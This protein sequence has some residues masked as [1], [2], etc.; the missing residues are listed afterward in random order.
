MLW[1]VDGREASSIPPVGRR[2]QRCGSRRGADGAGAG[3]GP[4]LL[5]RERPPGTN[6]PWALTVKVHG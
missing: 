4:G 5:G 2:A 6:Q 3:G 1:E